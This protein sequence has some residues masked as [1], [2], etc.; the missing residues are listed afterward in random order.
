MNPSDEDKL[1]ISSFAVEQ[2]YKEYLNYD[3]NSSAW[4]GNIYHDEQ[5]GH[6]LQVFSI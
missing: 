6:F 1:A 3:Q 2:W 4:N 5:I